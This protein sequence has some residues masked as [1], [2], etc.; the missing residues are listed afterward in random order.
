MRGEQ[1]IRSHLCSD[2][3]GGR[4]H[5]KGKYE[6]HIYAARERRK[7]KAPAVRERRKGKALVI[8]TRMKA[9]LNKILNV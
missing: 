5:C 8:R 6:G 4:A 9:V 1:V 7:G 3:G 2:G